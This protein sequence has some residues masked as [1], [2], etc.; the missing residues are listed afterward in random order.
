M[1]RDGQAIPVIPPLSIGEAVIDPSADQ[2]WAVP[3]WGS[4]PVA[5]PAVRVRRPRGAGR[6]LALLAAVVAAVA[7]ALAGCTAGTPAAHASVR[8]VWDGRHPHVWVGQDPM[9]WRGIAGRHGWARAD[10]EGSR[11]RVVCAPL[12]G[13]EYAWDAVTGGAR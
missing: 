1:N 10:R 2:T 11:F 7:L 5:V 3:A 13:G 9:C 8:P 12:G 4:V 6:K